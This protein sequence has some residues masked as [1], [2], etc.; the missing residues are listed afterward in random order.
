MLNGKTIAFAIP[1]C[2]VRLCSYDSSRP[3]SYVA[4]GSTLLLPRET[5]I[6]TKRSIYIQYFPQNFHYYGYSL[7]IMIKV[8]K[9]VCC[10][11]DLLIN[12]V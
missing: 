5:E 11:Y 3:K 6:D 8:I 2:F 7:Y 4:L 1:L 9:H 10:V 12:H